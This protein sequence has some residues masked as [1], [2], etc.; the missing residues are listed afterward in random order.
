Y[1]IENYSIKYVP[2][3]TS[4]TLLDS[5]TPGEGKKLL[6]VAGSQFSPE[7]G[8]SPK[9]PLAAL[10]STLIEVDSIAS[11]FK[12]SSVL[13]NREVSEGTVKKLL[14]RNNYR[15]IHFATHGMIDE[16]RPWRSGLALSIKGK[17][18]ASSKEDGMLRSAEIFG[19]RLNT[20]MV[21][22]SACNTGLGEVVSG[23]GILGMQRAFFFAGASTVVVSLWNVY[24]RSTAFLMNRFYDFA[25]KNTDDVEW[26]DNLLRWVGWDESVPFGQKAAAMRKA[27]LEM[28]NHPLYHHPVYWAPFIVVGR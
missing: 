13:T 28:I 8:S 10:P 23:E 27:K 1:L 26:V 12:Q 5:F 2:S 7:L 18:T 15:F 22:L 19:L 21:V 17:L 20:E 16:E 4:L 3:M 11:H 6:A 9:H 14:N 24:D 25:L